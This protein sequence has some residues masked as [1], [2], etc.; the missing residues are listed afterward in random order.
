M[1]LLDKIEAEHGASMADFDIEFSRP[2]RRII[3][4]S[5]YHRPLDL[6]DIKPKAFDDKRPQGDS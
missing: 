1:E 6:L 5:G 2:A 3:R 4:S